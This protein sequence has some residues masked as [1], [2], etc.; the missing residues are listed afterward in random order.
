MKHNLVGYDRLSGRII[1]EIPLPQNIDIK[2]LI[3]FDEDDPKGI[4]CYP[5][6]LDFFIEPSR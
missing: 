4:G 1:V 6:E 5:L 3:V 2:K